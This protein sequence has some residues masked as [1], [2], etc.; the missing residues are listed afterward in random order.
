MAFHILEEPLPGLK[1]IQPDVFGDHRGFFMEMWNV[2]HFNKIGLDLNLMQ[3]NLSYS[4]QGTLR[5]LHFQAPP[6]G[7]GKLVTVI[8]GQVLD[9]VVDIRKSSPTYGKHYAIELSRENHLMFFV[10]PGFAHGFLV[11]SETALFHY[12]V[13]HAG[14]NKASEGGLQWDDPALGIDWGISNPI[15]SEKDKAYIGFDA[16]QSPFE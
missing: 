3:D 13:S 2:N 12:K 8:D 16:F 14:Y 10:P 5:G 6:H 9:V 1:V 11:Q 15:L 4:A 7:Q